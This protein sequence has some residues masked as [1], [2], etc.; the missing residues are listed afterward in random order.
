MVE[1]SVEARYVVSSKL[2]G[3]TIN[4]LLKLNYKNM[5]GRKIMETDYYYI[6]DY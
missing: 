4:F 6:Y 2:T 5:K 1:R 3:S